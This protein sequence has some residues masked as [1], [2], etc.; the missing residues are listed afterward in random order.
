LFSPPA[1]PDSLTGKLVSFDRSDLT[2][3]TNPSDVPRRGDAATE[4]FA[5]NS[6]RVCFK[7]SFQ[8]AVLA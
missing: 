4:D 3:L 8:G 6:Q 7:L 5:I 2:D 1:I